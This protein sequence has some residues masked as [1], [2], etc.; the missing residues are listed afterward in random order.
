MI[1]VSTLRLQI[2]LHISGRHE[3]FESTA[4]PIALRQINLLIP[5]FAVFWTREEKHQ[6]MQVSGNELH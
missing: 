2:V 4:K 1:D 3:C 5:V 6:A